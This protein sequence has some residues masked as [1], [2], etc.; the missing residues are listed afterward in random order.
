MK[1]T[2]L[3]ISEELINTA[4]KIIA[5]NEDIKFYQM[6]ERHGGQID[7]MRIREALEDRKNLME[8]KQELKKELKNKALDEELIKSRII[9]F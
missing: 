4:Q 7:P 2:I 8:V 3:K 1:R 5:L 6:V 9:V